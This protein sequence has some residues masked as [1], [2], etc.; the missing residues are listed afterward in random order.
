MHLFAGLTNVDGLDADALFDVSLSRV[1]RVLVLEH[2]ALAQGVYKGCSS[3]ARRA[4]P[5]H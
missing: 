3:S 2:A 1:F 5:E 4:W